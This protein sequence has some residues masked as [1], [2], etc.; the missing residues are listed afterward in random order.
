LDSLIFYP[1]TISNLD[2]IYALRRYDRRIAVFPGPMA[3][4]APNAHPHGYAATVSNR[5]LFWR[6]SVPWQ[7]HG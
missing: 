3:I 4:Y 2:K 1:Q 6:L 7:R 5:I